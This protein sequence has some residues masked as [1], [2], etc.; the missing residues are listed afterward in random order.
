MCLERFR[1]FRE[2]IRYNFDALNSLASIRLSLADKREN[3]EAQFLETTHS[4]YAMIEHFSS[5]HKHLYIEGYIFIL[6]IGN[7]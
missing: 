5:Q 6:W 4:V 1:D 2:A 7:Y 3:A